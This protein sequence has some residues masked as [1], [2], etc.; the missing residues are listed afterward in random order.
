MFVNKYVV[1]NLEKT[2]PSP[3]PPPPLNTLTFQFPVS[4]LSSAQFLPKI[5]KKPFAMAWLN[6]D[7]ERK[8]LFYNKAEYIET[9]SK[10]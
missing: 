6:S 3:P 5:K 9:V 8:D 4:S 1:L 7:M 2:M 10:M